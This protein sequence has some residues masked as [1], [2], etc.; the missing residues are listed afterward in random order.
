LK[1]ETFDTLNKSQKSKKLINEQS[2][3]VLAPLSCPSPKVLKEIKI[4]AVT[5]T[6]KEE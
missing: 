4:E 2:P 1:T 5:Q 6:K 3:K